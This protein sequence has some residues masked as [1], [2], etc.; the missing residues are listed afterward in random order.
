MGISRASI[1]ILSFRQISP[2]LGQRELSTPKSGLTV[3]I[4]QLARRVSRMIQ[5][6]SRH[7]PWQSKCLVQAMAAKA[8]LRKRR[9]PTTLYL[10][11]AKGN[12]ADLSAH[13]WLRSGNQIITGGGNLDLYVV[14]TTFGDSS[15]PTQSN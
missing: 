13:A 7:M 11:V 10:G 15:I 3:E 4:E 12:G 5:I 2:H 6:A 9:V 14:V 1:R 8:M